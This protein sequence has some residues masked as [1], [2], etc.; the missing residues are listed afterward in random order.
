MTTNFEA[1]N[2]LTVGI[3]SRRVQLL[4]SENVEDMDKILKEICEMEVEIMIEKKKELKELYKSKEDL[5]QQSAA[6]QVA[7]DEVNLSINSRVAR[8]R[9]SVASRIGRLETEVNARIG[10]MEPPSMDA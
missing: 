4:K 7:L 8:Y 10:E 6:L 5:L 1:I 2:K 9:D 3:T